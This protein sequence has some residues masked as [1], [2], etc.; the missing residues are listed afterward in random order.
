[1]TKIF[2][3][4]QCEE[5]LKSLGI[6]AYTELFVCENP[7]CPNYSLVSVGLLP[8]DHINQASKMVRP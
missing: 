4:V 1:M 6:V 2:K 3:C 8:E 7:A 5:E